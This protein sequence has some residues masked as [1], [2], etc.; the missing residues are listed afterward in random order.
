M[1]I[2]V[3][4]ARWP[5]RGQMYCHMISDKGDLSELHAFAAKLGLKRLWFQNKPRWPHYDLAPST[6]R[7]AVQLGAEEVTSSEMVRRNPLRN[8][9]EIRPRTKSS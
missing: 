8:R 5:Y 6:R 2:L 9:G 3:D 7:L 1:A 4:E